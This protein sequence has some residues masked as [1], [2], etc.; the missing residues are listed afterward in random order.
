[1]DAAS[2]S[3]RPS[4]QLTSQNVHGIL[5][6]LGRARG[7]FPGCDILLDVDQLHIGSTEA[8][9]TLSGSGAELHH[10]HRSLNDRDGYGPRSPATKAAA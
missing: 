4:G 9:R 6:V 1:M 3:V 10:G 7:A 8:L 2:V 5:A